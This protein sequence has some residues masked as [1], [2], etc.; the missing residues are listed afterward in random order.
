MG[1]PP[2]SIRQS[3]KTR[4]VIDV[5]AAGSIALIRAIW[6]MKFT[7]HSRSACGTTIDP[8]DPGHF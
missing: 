2:I 6:V 1:G 8:G 5:L 3:V 4:V 7:R